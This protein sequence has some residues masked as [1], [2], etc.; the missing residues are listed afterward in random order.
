MD[1]AITIDNSDADLAI[2]TGISFVSAGGG[3]TNF[4][5]T[6]SSVFK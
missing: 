2:G 3:F 5:D 1:T 6:P 4:I